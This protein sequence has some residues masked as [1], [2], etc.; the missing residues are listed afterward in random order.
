MAPAVSDRP[1]ASDAGGASVFISAVCGCGSETGE[2][3]G[4]VT[5]IFAFLVPDKPK[6]PLDP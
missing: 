6:M 1:E 4:N 5:R 2:F 3:P